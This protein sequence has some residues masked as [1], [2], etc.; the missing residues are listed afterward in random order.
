MRKGWVK[1]SVK[2]DGVF[3]KKEICDRSVTIRNLFSF[4]IDFFVKKVY[5]RSKLIVEIYA[6]FF[7][8]NF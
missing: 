5:S 8:H 6:N 1:M 7:G 2:G 4:L 3:K